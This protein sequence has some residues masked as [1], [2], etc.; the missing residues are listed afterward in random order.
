M[1]CLTAHGA[2]AYPSPGTPIPD[3]RRCDDDRIA[4]LP[5]AFRAAPAPAHALALTS[6]GAR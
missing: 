2:T 5:I 1:P 6:A 3:P 4:Y